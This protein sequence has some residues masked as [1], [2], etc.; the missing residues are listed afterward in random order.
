MK[1][2]SISY[3]SY[4]DD[5]QL[6]LSLSPNEF[7]PLESLY[8]CLDQVH[9]W[10][11]RNLLKLNTDKTQVIIFGKKDQRLKVATLLGMKGFEVVE[12]VKNLGVIIDSDLS[13][14]SHMKS[15]TKS[16]FYH[17]KNIAKVKNFILPADLEKLIHAFISSRVDYCNG[18]FTGLPKKTIKSLQIIQNAAARLLTRT[19]RKD[20]ITP[21]LKSLH[22]LPVTYRIDFKVLFLV[23]KTLNGQGPLY[24][25]DMLQIYT[26]SRSLRYQSFS[27]KFWQED[28]ISA[29]CI[30][31]FLSNQELTISV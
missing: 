9:D 26:P 1:N 19:K 3:H 2:Y 11:S 16:S 31:S 30:T 6:Y 18:L 7:A 17:L 4:A 22:W 10:M 8:L 24:M 20:H 13:F 5:T 14:N 12:T 25:A 15:V 29:S 23:F 28:S 21:I 27:L